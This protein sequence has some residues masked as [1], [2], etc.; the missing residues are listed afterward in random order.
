MGSPPS[1]RSGVLEAADQD[2]DVDVDVVELDVLVDAINDARQ[3]GTPCHSGAL[4]SLDEDPAL[5]AAARSHV[6]WMVDNDDYA[7][8]TSGNPDGDHPSIRA[9]TMG[10]V[11]RVGE[12]IAWGQRSERRAVRWW[13]QSPA[14]CRILMDPQ[15]YALG[16]AVEADPESSG[17]VWVMMVGG[18]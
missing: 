7:H 17:W 8:I 1:M 9:R 10:F 5:T 4:S 12:N 13:I 14:H 3:Q 6:V 15:A 16:V 18:G 2:T 11:D